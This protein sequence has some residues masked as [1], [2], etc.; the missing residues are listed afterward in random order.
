M[1]GN[2]KWL[3]GIIA[4]VLIVV[5]AGWLLTT[6]AKLE[7]NCTDVAVLKSQFAQVKDDISEVKGLVTEIRRD[8]IR[9]ELRER[10]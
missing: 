8:Q 2:V 10:K 3:F 9:R 6:S 5:V 4:G 1:N 7:A